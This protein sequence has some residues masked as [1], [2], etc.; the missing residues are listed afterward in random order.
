MKTPIRAMLLDERLARAG[1]VLE[2]GPRYAFAFAETGKIGARE[3]AVGRARHAEVAAAVA[4]GDDEVALSAQAP[5]DRRLAVSGPADR[6]V[7]EATV[8]DHLEF[9]PG[10]THQLGCVHGDRGQSFAP[11]HGLDPGAKAGA[12]HCGPGALPQE[13]AEELAESPAQRRRLGEVGE[14]K[15]AGHPQQ[16]DGLLEGIDLGHPAACDGCLE[17]R[18]LRDM[19][20]EHHGHAVVRRDRAVKVQDRENAVEVVVIRVSRVVSR[21]HRVDS[22]GEPLLPGRVYWDRR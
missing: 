9:M 7:T 4:E 2:R 16:T 3:D 22:T 1:E 6:A 5:D 11:P 13:P 17:L 10:L 18:P 12:D 21:R 20:S 15:L 19:A 8:E 14:D